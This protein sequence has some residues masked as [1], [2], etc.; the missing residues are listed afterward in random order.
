M[1]PFTLPD[2]AEAVEGRTLLL[3]VA[4][5]AVIR[6]KSRGQVESPRQSPDTPADT[7]CSRS[8]RLPAAS[9]RSEGLANRR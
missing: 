5:C 9:R 6:V 7:E 1:S 3:C 2:S 4:P 8:W